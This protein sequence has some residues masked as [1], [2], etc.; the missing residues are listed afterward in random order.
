MICFSV[1][2]E[3]EGELYDGELWDIA[4]LRDGCGGY[5]SP[6]EPLALSGNQGIRE[7]GSGGLDSREGKTLGL[8]QGC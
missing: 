3:E 4:S 1:G 6:L 2:V 7:G 8:R 5:C